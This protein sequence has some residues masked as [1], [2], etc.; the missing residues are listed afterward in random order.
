MDGPITFP[1][2]SSRRVSWSHVEGSLGGGWSRAWEPEHVR[3]SQ[4]SSCSSR[5][6]K[7][8]ALVWSPHEFIRKWKRAYPCSST[9]VNSIQFKT[10]ASSAVDPRAD[11]MCQVVSWKTN[12]RTH[13][14]WMLLTYGYGSCHRPIISSFSAIFIIHV[15]I[16]R[17]SSAVRVNTMFL[18]KWCIFTVQKL[19]EQWACSQIAA[20]SYTFSSATVWKETLKPMTI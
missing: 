4:L 13:K 19:H 11:W 2:T 1:P 3:T 15:I 8:D 6:I 17:G 9:I 16:R 5:K 18:Q 12:Y 7:Q 14:E 20:G 10:H